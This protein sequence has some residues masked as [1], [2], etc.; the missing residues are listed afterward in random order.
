MRR[1]CSN[2]S[3]YEKSIFL[4][5]ITTYTSHI[6]NKISQYGYRRSVT[7]ILT[8]TNRLWNKI[9]Q[10]GYSMFS[11][12]ISTSTSRSCHNHKTCRVI[13]ILELKSCHMLNVLLSMKKI[14]LASLTIVTIRL[15]SMR[16]LRLFNPFCHSLRMRKT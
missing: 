14:L 12:I 11:P 16:L 6:C 7:C 15:I 9:S 5:R 8:T 4:P 3:R 2:I 10:F 13:K 1:L